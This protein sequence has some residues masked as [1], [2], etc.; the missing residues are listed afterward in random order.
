MRYFEVEEDIY[1]YR[2]L[3]SLAKECFNNLS[4]L[5]EEDNVFVANS[6]S[7]V[8]ESITIEL[9]EDTVG[10]EFSTCEPQTI[11]EENLGSEVKSVTQSKNTFLKK[12]TGRTVSDRRTDM[13][14]SVLP[15]VE[16]IQH[17]EPD[18]D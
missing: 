7:P 9:T 1:T 18:T 5:D 4:E 6:Q 13:R 12:A 3:K 14:K 10:L 2:E 15:D 17:P 16:A 11:V 8:V